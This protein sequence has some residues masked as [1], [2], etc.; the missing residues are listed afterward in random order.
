MAGGAA[1]LLLLLLPLPAAEP[2]GAED[3]RDSEEAA[4]AEPR[5]GLALPGL[6]ALES[7]ELEF[8][9]CT[10][11]CGIGIREVLLT[12][13]CP[14]SETKCIVG[15]EECH[16]PVD[17]G[18]GRPISENSESV[19]MTCIY[20]PPENRFK[21]VWKILTPNKTARILPNDSAVMEVRRDTR[22]ITYQC[23]TQGNESVIAS[24]KYTVHAT[25]ELQTKQ[26]ERIDTGQSRKKRADAILVFCLVTGIIFMVGV[27]FAIIFIILHW[28]IVKTV[29]ES[30]NGQDDTVEKLTI[31]SSQSNM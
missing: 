21:Y 8:G 19:M 12:N 9:V 17:C 29:L 15:V 27:I 6:N 20:I 16:G 26:S 1:L 7:M 14:G 2:P 22:P 28:A 24:V 13:G 10:V 30:K 25:T 5:G 4:A 11:T 18:L 23:E 3:D 31:K